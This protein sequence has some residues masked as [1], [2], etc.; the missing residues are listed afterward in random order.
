MNS[1][2]SKV[3][4]K[5]WSI[6][7]NCKSSSVSCQV[8][9][10]RL[11]WKNNA[12]Y[13]FLSLFSEFSYLEHWHFEHQFTGIFI[14]DR[15]KNCFASRYFHTF[16]STQFALSFDTF[17]LIRTE[18]FSHHVYLL[19]DQNVSL[20]RSQC[21]NFTQKVGVRVCREMCKVQNGL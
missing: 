14:W 19:C 15:R 2:M 11:K 13:N 16:Q 12:N 17:C 5:C 8:D 4:Q 21:S 6:N 3:V 7:L 10:E 9:S 1:S 18:S 20:T